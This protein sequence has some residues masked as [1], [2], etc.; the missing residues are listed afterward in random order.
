MC[1]CER[2]SERMQ[3]GKKKV[4]NSYCSTGKWLKE[5]T[6]KIIINTYTNTAHSEAIWPTR[7]HFVWLIDNGE[8]GMKEE[9]GERIAS[10]AP[11]HSNR[12]VVAQQ[13]DSN[14]TTL[15][16]LKEKYTRT[17][18]KNNNVCCYCC[19]S[20]T[21]LWIFLSSVRLCALHVC[22]EHTL[23]LV[24]HQEPCVQRS[25]AEVGCIDRALRYWKA[26]VVENG[27]E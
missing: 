10:C 8:C 1:A 4:S 21:T 13:N 26:I 20:H 9:N 23:H 25:L 19:Y 16:S 18:R 12:T 3:S 17:T 22:V 7:A 27:T 6:L 24:S 2:G 11:Y 15:N 5:R 14:S